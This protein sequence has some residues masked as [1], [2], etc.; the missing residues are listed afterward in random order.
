MRS[1]VA[2]AAHSSAIALRASGCFFSSLSSSSSSSFIEALNEIRSS[3][4]LT[5]LA[6]LDL[7]VSW[8]I[9]FQARCLAFTVRCCSFISLIIREFLRH[10][11]KSLQD[12]RSGRDDDQEYLLRDLPGTLQEYSPDLYYQSPAIGNELDHRYRQQSRDI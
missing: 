12:H 8:I 1:A 4:V 3:F 9:L 7:H 2:C 10:P 11:P 6:Q 5:R